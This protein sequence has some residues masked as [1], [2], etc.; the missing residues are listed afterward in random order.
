MLKLSADQKKST[1]TTVVHLPHS[2]FFIVV[3]G[4]LSVAA[5][6]PPA[7]AVS[8]FTLPIYTF[9]LDLTIREDDGKRR[10]LLLPQN[11]WQPQQQL[12][13]LRKG[14]FVSGDYNYSA[15]QHKLHSEKLT[16]TPSIGN[17]L[18]ATTTT[19]KTPSVKKLQISSE[20]TD[21]F[22]F[23]SWGEIETYVEDEV[24]DDDK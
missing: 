12:S 6:L 2:L 4:I 3:V 22:N 11:G 7:L 19:T 1:M 10:Q 5:A 17:S 15:N 21:E 20:D 9:R 14:S 13:L 16:A 24:E 18:T 23:D 8:T